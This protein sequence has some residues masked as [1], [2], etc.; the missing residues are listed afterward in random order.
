MGF[1]LKDIAKAPAYLTVVRHVQDGPEIHERRDT[2]HVG[3]RDVWP[4]ERGV[5]EV[6]PEA[7]V[8]AERVARGAPKLPAV[9]H[10]A[11]AIRP[12]APRPV[13]PK[14][15]VQDA[16]VALLDLGARR[17]KRRCLGRQ[18]RRSLGQ[19]RRPRRQLRR[20]SGAVPVRL[21]QGIF[22]PTSSFLYGTKGSRR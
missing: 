16:F 2:P 1:Y 6:V 19:L 15:T 17:L 13:A 18:L 20:K 9:H 22:L 7:P 14:R 10:A 3:A 5:L 21:E 12:V 11:P 4:S 8:E